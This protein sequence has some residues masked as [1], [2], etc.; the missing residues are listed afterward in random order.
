[1]TQGSGWPV[2]RDVEK[3]EVVPLR[4]YGRWITALALGVV[5]AGLLVSMIT[6]PRFKWDIV[7]HYLFDDSIIAGLM[8]TIWL[9]VAAMGIGIVLGTA[10]ALM[11]ISDNPVL[12][13]IAGGYLWIFRG[14]PLLVQL[15]F[16]YNLSALYPQITIGFPFG[17]SL[18]SF[19]ANR[20][21]TVYVAALLGLGLNEGAYMSEIVRS[22]LNAVATGQREAAE[23]LGMSRFRVMARIILPQAMRVIIPPTGNQLI[24]MLKT[25]SLVSVIA[26][27]ELLYSA[28]LIYTANFQ[29]IPLLI[30][31]SAWYLVLTTLLSIGQYFVERHFGRSDRRVAAAPDVAIESGK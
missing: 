19:D 29:T 31:A 28:Q 2:G 13:N 8:M 12:S 17:P 16:W 22:G 25:T 23:A 1:M 3:M 21:I 11:R 24:G 30:V 14:T 27:Q 18:G 15:I 20:Y 6:N 10:V 26:L 4:Y 9:T 7:A 5:L